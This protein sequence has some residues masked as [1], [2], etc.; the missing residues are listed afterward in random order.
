MRSI[1]ATTHRAESTV[2]ELVTRIHLKLGVSRRAELV[3]MVLSLAGRER[4]PRQDSR[5]SPGSATP[6]AAAGRALAASMF[7]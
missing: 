4:I 6:A 3:R 2:R 5:S 7:A 1:A